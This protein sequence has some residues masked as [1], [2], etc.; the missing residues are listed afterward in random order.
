MLKCIVSV[1]AEQDIE[2]I[3]R[4]TEEQ[5]G[6]RARRRYE[7]LLAQ[8]IVDLAENA[9]RAGSQRR[10]EI[11]PLAR[12]YHLWHSRK[13]ANASVEGVEK[14]RHFILF[15]ISGSGNLEIGRVLH[16]SMELGRPL[17]SEYRS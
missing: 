4:W 12:T 8:A 17:P 9:D 10:P 1:A 16:D 2:S 14:P 11:A 6:E 5:F 3:L 15:R 7:A 13:R